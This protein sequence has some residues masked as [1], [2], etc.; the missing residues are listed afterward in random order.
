MCGLPI[1]QLGY[2]FFHPE[3]FHGCLVLQLKKSAN[4]RHRKKQ[5]PPPPPTAISPVSQQMR[6][7]KEHQ[8]RYVTKQKGGGGSIA[9]MHRRIAGGLELLVR[10]RAGRGCW[11][12]GWWC[13][14]R[15]RR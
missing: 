1:I 15:C 3:Q 4:R 9:N 12:R 6:R 10:S 14:R 7:K 5:K 8:R 11:R 2:F 13:W